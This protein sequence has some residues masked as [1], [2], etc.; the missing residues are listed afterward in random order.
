MNN[1]ARI[2]FSLFF[3]VTLSLNGSLPGFANTPEDGSVLPFPPTPSG[4]K[5]AQS[6]QDSTYQPLPKPRRLSEDAPNILIVLID[7]AGPA[8]PDTYGG[9]IHTPTLSRIAEQG[10]SFNRFHTTAMCFP[11]SCRPANRPQSPSCRC[12]GHRITWQ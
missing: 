12:R 6:M 5:A 2:F 3:L 1:P 11:Y 8:L 10:I 9:E 7:D 4:S